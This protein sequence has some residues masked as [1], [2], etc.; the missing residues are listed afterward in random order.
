[1]SELK[2]T[3]VVASTLPARF[4]SG[5]P[6]PFDKLCALRK[7]QP[8]GE[9]FNLTQFGVNLVTIPPSAWSSQRHWHSKEDEFILILEGRPT[10]VTDEGETELSPGM[11]TGFPAGSSNGHHLIN[12]TDADVVYVEVGSR[13]DADDVTY[14]D[15]DM[16]VKGRGLGGVFTRK[17][18]ESYV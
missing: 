13:Y 18:G 5:Y 2:A 6:E 12:N 7:K 14:S 17:N 4:G 3:A 9:P 1:M 15:I 10:L 8:L 11:C 16:Q